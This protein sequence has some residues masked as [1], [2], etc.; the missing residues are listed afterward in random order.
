MCLSLVQYPSVALSRVTRYT[1]SS[2]FL[3]HLSSIYSFLWSTFCCYVNLWWRHIIYFWWHILDTFDV[4]FWNFVLWYFVLGNFWY[5][6]YKRES[7]VIRNPKYVAYRIYNCI[8]MTVS[9]RFS[10]KAFEVAIKHVC[11]FC[12]L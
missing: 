12:K 8:F 6:L 2:I 5:F 10:E 11:I 9:F 3:S 4:N 7:V 1:H